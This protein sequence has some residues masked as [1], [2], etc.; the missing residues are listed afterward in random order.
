MN[1][2][3]Y[4]KIAR[5]PRSHK[6]IAKIIFEYIFKILLGYNKSQILNFHQRPC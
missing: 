2:Q 5:P 3:F 4:L 1:F 6:S